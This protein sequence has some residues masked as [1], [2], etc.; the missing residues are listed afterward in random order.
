MSGQPYMG[1]RWYAV[2]DDLVGGWGLATV[3]KP[4]SQIDTYVTG[5]RIVGCF[6]D[7]DTAR[8][9]AHLHNST[10]AGAGTTAA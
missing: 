1:Q 8:H 7:E 5:E 4:T 3:D 9:L 10:V 6:M 2:A